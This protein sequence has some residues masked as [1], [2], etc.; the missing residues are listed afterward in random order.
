M[1]YIDNSLAGHDY[2]V[3][4]AQNFTGYWRIGYDN[5]ALWPDEPRSRFIAGLID[6]IRIYNRP[7]ADLEISVL[8][9]ENT[10]GI[11]DE[12]STTPGLFSLEQNYPNPFNPSTTIKYTLAFDSKVLIK[13]YNVLGQEVRL[14]KDEIISAGEYEVKFNSSSLPS[15]VYFYRLNADP[16]NGGQKYS[17]IKK[18]ML[19]K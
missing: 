10:V 14:L 13:I 15:G 16:L 19:L 7:L 12:K 2:S 18:M 9:N 5:L 8:Y 17:S 6:D 11:K 4:S 1:L 3:T